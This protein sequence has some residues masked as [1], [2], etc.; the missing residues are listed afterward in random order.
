VTINPTRLRFAAKVLVLPLLACAV[1][2]ADTLARIGWTGENP[3]YLQEDEGLS[4]TL[5]SHYVRLDE[6]NVFGGVIRG[7]DQSTGETVGISE[8]EVY[9]VQESKVIHKSITNV[10]GEFEIGQ[11]EAGTYS[12]CVA[13]TNGF[14]AHG[15]HFI[16]PVPEGADP[17]DQANVEDSLEIQTS[18]PSAPAQITAAVVP[19]EFTALRE[20]MA[21]LLPGT[22][23]GA[24]GAGGDG[25]QINVEK[26]VIAGGFKISLGENGSMKGRIAP[27]GNEKDKPIRINDMN[28][29]LILDDEVYARASVDTDGNFEFQDI[30][31]GV[32]GFAAA[33][34]DGFA[35]ISFQAVVP[36]DDSTEAKLESDSDV[37]LASTSVGRL[38]GIL[39]VA[40]CPPE[41][42]IFLKDKIEELTGGPQDPSDLPI[43]VPEVPVPNANAPLT[44]F[45]GDNFGGFNGLGDGAPIVDGGG[46]QGGGI[47]GGG[48]QGGGVPFNRRR[49]VRLGI[50]GG[51][52]GGAVA[53]SVDD[54]ESPVTPEPVSPAG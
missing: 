30:E 10:D 23:S 36:E 18:W 26:S 13:G 14:L 53:L 9:L 29:F 45:Q 46:F 3:V 42:N 22:V 19:P 15:I 8:L 40:I 17:D 35:A 4:E 31:P 27:I 41:D 28:A 51:I 11:I 16:E 39:E 7:I 2:G 20:I 33:G 47:Q 44:P 24:V 49:L 38:A 12:F 48:V 50:L 6:G 43:D 34:K 32:Y 37:Q 1:F 54:G 5:S 21:D 52:I 25:I